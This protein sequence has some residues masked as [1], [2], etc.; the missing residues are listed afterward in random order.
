MRMHASDDTGGINCVEKSLAKPRRS[1]LV[2]NV[3]VLDVG[4]CFWPDNEDSSHRALRREP[5]IRPFT[6]AQLAPAFGS[7]RYASALRRSSARW[8]SVMGGS[9]ESAGRLSHSATA[10]S[11]R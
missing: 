5:W 11:T 8:G 7:R 10:S 9:S 4:L 1:S 3:R 6:S 2:P